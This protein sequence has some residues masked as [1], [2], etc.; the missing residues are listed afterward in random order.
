[1]KNNFVFIL[2]L[3]FLI[4]TSK[5]QVGFQTNMVGYTALP[6]M[7][8]KHISY[9]L[10]V[11]VQVFKGFVLKTSGYYLNKTDTLIR[12]R[13]LVRHDRLQ[14]YGARFSI[15]QYTTHLIEKNKMPEGFYIG[16]Y[17]DFMVGNR[18]VMIVNDYSDTFEHRK[19][20][21]IS[22]GCNVGYTYC[23][24]RFTLEPNIGI[25]VSHVSNQLV[26]QGGWFNVDPEEQ[27]LSTCHFQLNV[28]YRF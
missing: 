9:E 16:S 25:G 28:G 26:D 4:N 5:A 11:E 19:G 1:M 3:L 22:I 6:L 27:S 17:N 14:K 12:A 10:G 20:I 13:K 23:T 8:P 21:Y 15:K 18:D 24:R 2:F 7:F